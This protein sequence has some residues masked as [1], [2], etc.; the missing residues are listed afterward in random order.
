[1]AWK[2]GFDL[3]RAVYMQTLWFIR[4]YPDLKDEYMALLEKS[5]AMDG[6]PRGTTPGDPTGQTAVKISELSDRI[7]TIDRALGEVPAEYR[8]SLFENIV[9]RVPY[10]DYASRNTWKTWRRRFVY[11]VAVMMRFL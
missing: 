11:S 5:H 9:Y 4:S 6:Q 2:N 1:M 7:H 10:K 3:P 8:Q